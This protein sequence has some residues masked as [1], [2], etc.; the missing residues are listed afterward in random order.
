MTEPTEAAV[1]ATSTNSA[2]AAS[3]ASLAVERADSLGSHAT[4]DAA[5]RSR[6]LRDHL[7]GHVLPRANSLDAPLL[8]LLFGPTGAGKSSLLNA[9]TG[10]AASEAGV[11]RPTTRE[12]VVL[13]R[14]GARATLLG[15][16]MAL[17]ALA[18]DRVRFIESEDV[19]E[20]VA[21]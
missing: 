5:R 6:Q 4:E 11:L 8:V 9:L 20:G 19:A 13:A 3:L 2:A 7:V 17:A 21:L 16:G 18:G 15:E 10:F 1:R 14:P 12:V